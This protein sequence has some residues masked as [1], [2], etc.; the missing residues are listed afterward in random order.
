MMIIPDAEMENLKM[1]SLRA[2]ARE[3]HY[4]WAKRMAESLERKPSE[5]ELRGLGRVPFFEAVEWTY[6]YLKKLESRV[7]S[8]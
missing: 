4:L 5:I 1:G 7:E 2:A 3:A 8:K 6:N